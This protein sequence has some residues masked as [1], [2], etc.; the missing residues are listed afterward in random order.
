[1]HENQILPNLEI[2]TP[3][4]N[5][6]YFGFQ[7]QNLNKKEYF[8]DRSLQMNKYIKVASPPC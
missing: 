5:T 7:F 6:D 1:M 4:M 2:S 8:L 3:V